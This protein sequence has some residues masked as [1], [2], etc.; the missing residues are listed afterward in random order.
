MSMYDDKNS[1]KTEIIT[2]HFLR[3]TLKTCKFTIQNLI[4]QSDINNDI[5][6][7]DNKNKKETRYFSVCIYFWL[8][9]E[10]NLYLYGVYVLYIFFV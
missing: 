6:G 7:E 9:H 2:T 5:C 8:S 3:A 10:I 1:N 4:C